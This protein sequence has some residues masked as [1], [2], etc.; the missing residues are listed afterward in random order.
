MD[1][2][3]IYSGM[4]GGVVVDGCLWFVA[5]RKN[6]ICRMDLS[7]YKT[8]FVCEIPFA[9]LK[10]HSYK[11]ETMYN[12][13]IILM[14][15]YADYILEYNIHTGTFRKTDLKLS[16]HTSGTVGGTAI[17]FRS[18]VK[19]GDI[20]WMMPQSCHCIIEYNART[21][22]VSEHNSW[23]KQFEKYNWNN[24]NLFGMGI[25]ANE[26]LWIPC[27]QLNAVLEFSVKTKASKLHF[28]GNE[29]SFYSAII[30][31][32]EK[33]W[34]LD[35]VNKSIIQWDSKT[36]EI[37]INNIFSDG[38]GLEKIYANNSENEKYGVCCMY[39][40]NNRILLLPALANQFVIFDLNDQKT[41]KLTDKPLGQSYVNAYLSTDDRALCFSQ[42]GN[43][44][45][46]ISSNGTLKDITTFSI[47][48]GMEN[49]YS[50][51]N[52]GEDEFAFGEFFELVENEN[53]IKE[54]KNCNMSV[55]SAIYD[56][57]INKL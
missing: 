40:L 49:I 45:V 18:S 9:K 39:A 37:N 38:Y 56:K 30:Y 55:G 8:Q 51:R 16:L 27:Y 32:N 20:I 19:D 29:G 33:F 15:E 28:I 31:M 1:K 54:H 10:D 22:T 48:V 2:I 11:I 35:N 14:P 26:S 46:E 41:T 50:D 57:L 6:W 23:Y 5:T 21:H 7:D 52:F 42:N 4:E 44:M 43:V 3:N 53:L 47:E 36:G 17:K 34:L 13:N 12:D 24:V 25:M